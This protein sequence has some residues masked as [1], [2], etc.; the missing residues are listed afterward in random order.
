MMTEVVG[1]ILIKKSQLFLVNNRGNWALPGGKKEIGE[2]DL[3]CLIREI[4][5]EFAG[6][7]IIP[8]KC[9]PY[10]IFQ[11]VS[12]RN[13]TPL[14]LRT[15]FCEIAGKI[16]SP[17]DPERDIL[18][19]QWISDFSSYNLSDLTKDVVQSLRSDGYLS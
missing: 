13:R 17:S 6:T 10:K 12:P 7:V 18:D 5:E 9:L 11:G 3:E 19:V 8:E 2:Q 14:S 16:A 4:N 1:A 15:Y